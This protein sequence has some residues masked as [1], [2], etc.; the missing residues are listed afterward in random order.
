MI[1][2]SSGEY[3]EGS[4]DKRIGIITDNRYDK[5]NSITWTKAIIP[6]LPEGM[7]NL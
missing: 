2:K 5:V 7:K 3:P 6:G 4:D 1:S